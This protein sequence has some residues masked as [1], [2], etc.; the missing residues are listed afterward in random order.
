[1]SAQ[2][3]TVNAATSRPASPRCSRPPTRANRKRP[4]GTPRASEPQRRPVAAGI[5]GRLE[6]IGEHGDRLGVAH[7]VA[8]VVDEADVL[9]AA[10]GELAG[11]ALAEP[12]L[13]PKPAVLLA[14]CA[15]EQP[16]RRVD[17]LL[18][19]EAVVH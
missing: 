1:M 13:E 10:R 17:R 12:R 6:A 3:T 11:D 5:G 7:H 14:P 2:L 16:A 9:V 19:R 4:R 18:H 15:P 8:P